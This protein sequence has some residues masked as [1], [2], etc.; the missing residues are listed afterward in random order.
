MTGEIV[1]PFRSDGVIFIPERRPIGK[2]LTEY[3][4]RLGRTA[5]LTQTDLERLFESGEVTLENLVNAQMKQYLGAPLINS[6]GKSFGVMTMVLMEETQ[7]F[8]TDDVK[9]LSIIAG[10]GLDGHR[11]QTGGGRTCCAVP[12]VRRGFTCQIKLP[13]QYVALNWRTPL[14][15]IIGFSGSFGR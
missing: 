3:I 11:T 13:S 10:A 5:L 6:Q 12:K 9:V 14:N 4:L 15:A 2:G 8:L 7:T 1:A